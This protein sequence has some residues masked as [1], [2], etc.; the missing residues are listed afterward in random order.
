M[1]LLTPPGLAGIAVLAVEARERA[2]VAASLHSASGATV[3]PVVGGPPVRAALVLDGEVVDD[4]LAL[5]RADGELELHVHGAPAVIDVLDRRFGVRV[6]EPLDPAEGL[7]RAAM[8]VEQLDLALEQRAY[9]FDRELAALLALPVRQRRDGLVEVLRRS[10]VARAL[11]SPQRVALVGRQNAGK[12][13]L[14]N[15]LLF[16]ERA[17]VGAEPGLTR[18]AIVEATTL[19]G[20]PY[21]LIDT[22]GEGVAAEEPDVLAIRRG[23]ELRAG[24]LVVLVVDG[25]AGFDDVDRALLPAAALVVR[26]KADLPAGAWPDDVRCDAVVS[27]RVDD[28]DELRARLGA[29]LRAH[30]GLPPAGPV[31]GFAALDESGWQR[32]EALADDGPAPPPQA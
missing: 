14:F 29:V 9:D 6:D 2:A 15:R 4:V 11:A 20:Y 24:A 26:N 21:E 10:R 22:A 13:S 28:A 16:R 12:S 31:G 18:D 8:S 1:K 3:A 27:S 30:R 32:L 25:A 17:L 19:A 7:L 23:R 5:V